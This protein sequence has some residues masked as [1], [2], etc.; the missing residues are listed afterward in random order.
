M[1]SLAEGRIPMDWKRADIVPIFKAGNKKDLLN[2]R[3]VCL[4]SVV[5]K[6]CEWLIKDRWMKHLEKSKVLMDMQFGFREGRSCATNLINFYSRVVD[7]VQERD[8]WVDCIYL[9]LRKA[10]DKVADKRLLWKS[11][12]IGGLKEGF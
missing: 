6:I 1:R 8:G 5:V 3:P 4:T 11:D 10:F 2:Y 9:D 7:I 12:S